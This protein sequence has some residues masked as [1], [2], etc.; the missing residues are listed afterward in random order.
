VRNIPTTIA[1][2][3]AATAITI[4]SAAA[5]GGPKFGRSHVSDVSQARQFG[6]GSADYPPGFSQGN[7]RGWNG[8]AT[9]PGWSHGRK[10][11][12]QGRSTPPGWNK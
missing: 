11:G 10:R 6:W 9:P 8:A 7:K 3:F 12:W 4:G 1:V 5:K 2:L